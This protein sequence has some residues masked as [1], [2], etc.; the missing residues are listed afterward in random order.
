MKWL[1]NKLGYFPKS[2]IR[3]RLKNILIYNGENDISESEL[4]FM[5]KEF[6]DL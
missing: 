3:S 5:V 6:L 1:M 4:N 2:E